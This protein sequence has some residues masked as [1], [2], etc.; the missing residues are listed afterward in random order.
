M[1]TKPS[2]LL[3]SYPRSGNTLLQ[4]LLYYGFGIKS[5]SLY[6]EPLLSGYHD[7]RSC[8]VKS[9]GLPIAD[10][11]AIYIVRDGREV[12]VSYWHYLADGD[13]PEFARPDA[14]LA[15]VIRGDVVFGSW[16]DHLRAWDPLHRP[17]TFCVRYEDMLGTPC[18]VIKRLA[19]QIGCE[20]TG[21]GP[22]PFGYFHKQCPGFF[23]S[24]TN[25][26]WK[27]EMTGD[28]LDLFWELHGEA[29]REF[30]YECL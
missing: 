18:E 11:P 8:F 2:I 25:E 29:M 3:A 15:D 9:H 4:M 27:E 12:C 26:T 14:T 21:K 1:S 19:R 7:K 23:R 6:S 17:N 13:N 22:P 20:P 30:G 24:G 5:S 28:D 10:S 16:S